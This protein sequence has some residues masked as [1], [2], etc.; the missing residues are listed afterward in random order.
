[1]EDATPTRENWIKMLSTL[2]WNTFPE[3]EISPS[4]QNKSCFVSTL[5]RVLSI[6]TTFFWGP[7]L[8]TYRAR[9]GNSQNSFPSFSPPP[10][11][12]LFFSWLPTSCAQEEE[13]EEEDT[14]GR[15]KAEWIT[16]EDVLSHI[17]C[18]KR[19]KKERKLKPFFRSFEKAPCIFPHMVIGEGRRKKHVITASCGDKSE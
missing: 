12:S 11:F 3:K 6:N 8:S 5:F 18:M 14:K 19:K 15:R 10:S 13:E 1:M 9:G 17:H 7:L 2:F 4:E 16:S